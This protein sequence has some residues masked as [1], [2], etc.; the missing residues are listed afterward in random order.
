[1]TETYLLLEVSHSVRY[2]EHW[3]LATAIGRADRPSPEEELNRTV[4]TLLALL[5]PL[6]LVHREPVG[7]RIAVPV[8]MNKGVYGA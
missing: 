4:R 1:M 6:L 7:A 5:G 2:F 3:S 8:S